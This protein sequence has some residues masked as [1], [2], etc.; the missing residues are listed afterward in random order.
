MRNRPGI[1]QLAF[2]AVGVVLG[3][4]LG[5]IGPRAEMRALRAELE[6]RP[7]GDGRS[8]GAEVA[9]IFQGRGPAA[10]VD[11]PEPAPAGDPP[12]VVLQEDGEDV[13]ASPDGRAAPPPSPEPRDL[14]AMRDAMNVRARQARQALLEDAEPDDEQLA[15]IDQVLA[16][17]N[18]DLRVLATEFVDVYKASGEEPSRR[19]MMAFAADSLDVLITTEDALTDTLSPE[20]QDAL[21]EESLDPLSYVDGSLVDVLAELDG[22]QRDR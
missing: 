17:M 8:V 3:V 2:A 14:D 5:G 1:S 11:A 4:A 9:R 12:A 15:E 6:A 22:L 16:D 20:Q 18:A 21:S 10:E 13:E 7:Q 19:D